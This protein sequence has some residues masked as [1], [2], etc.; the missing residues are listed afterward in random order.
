MHR[1]IRVNPRHFDRP[2]GNC[3]GRIHRREGSA[4]DHSEQQSR[5]LPHEREVAGEE[6]SSRATGWVM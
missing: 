5:R 1:G 4:A 3:P 2:S 6:F